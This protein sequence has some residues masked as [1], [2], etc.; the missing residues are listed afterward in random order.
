MFGGGGEDKW[1]GIK[2]TVMSRTIEDDGSGTVITVTKTDKRTGAIR[3]DMGSAS[4]TSQLNHGAVGRDDCRR[5]LDGV[6]AMHKSVSHTIRD[7]EKTLMRRRI[8]DIVSNA[9]YHPGAE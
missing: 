7:L 4:V 9:E 8:S 3:G 5:N 1:L 6:V 2:K